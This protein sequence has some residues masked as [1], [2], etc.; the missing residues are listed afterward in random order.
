MTT[1]AARSS[2]VPNAGK[3]S[4]EA[5]RDEHVRQGFAVLEV[6]ERLGPEQSRAMYADDLAAQVRHVKETVPKLIPPEGAQHSY[7][8]MLGTT[9]QVRVARVLDYVLPGDRVFDIGLGF[10]YMACLLARDGRIG[11]YAGIDLTKDKIEKTRAM[12]ELNGLTTVPMHLEVGDLYDLTPDQVAAHQPTLFLTLEVLEHVPDAEAALTT[13]ANCMS[14]EA[15]ILFT[16]PVLGRIETVWGHVSLFDSARI[17]AMCARAG[18]A[19][20][21]IETVQDQWAFVLATKAP[22]VPDRLMHVLGRPQLT[23]GKPASP[24]L[25]FEDFPTKLARPVGSASIEQQGGKVRVTVRESRRLWRRQRQRNGIAVPIPGD[26]RLRFELSF[27]HPTAVKEVRV[28]VRDGRGKPTLSWVLNCTAEKPVI[29]TDKK[30]FV[31][32]PGRKLGPFVP[33]GRVKAGEGQTAEILV[34][35]KRGRRQAS[36]TLY[37]ASAAVPDPT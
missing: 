27:D 33:V 17:R 19:I 4:L 13:L 9:N 14:S 24:I 35:L 25:R 8:V 7:K 20:Q 18:L 11:S 22:S 26:A 36:F 1:T 5:I 30:I 31:F 15:A 10:G 29:A 6:L 12:A 2:P 21:H 34:E 28:K 32:G 37:R 3:T 23:A 16:V